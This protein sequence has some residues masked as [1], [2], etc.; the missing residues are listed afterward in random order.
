[1]PFTDFLNRVGEDGEI[2]EMRYKILQ[3]RQKEKKTKKKINISP[4]NTVK[5]E[6]KQID[7]KDKDEYINTQR[8]MIALFEIRRG[9][10]EILIIKLMIQM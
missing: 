9:N 2:M 4:E 1:M 5:L 10:L 7:Y 3:E 6:F 8:T